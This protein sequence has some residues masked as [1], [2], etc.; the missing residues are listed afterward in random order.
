MVNTR[1]QAWKWS[2]RI[3]M[4]QWFFADVANYHDTHNVSE[5]RGD[6]FHELMK[7][8]ISSSL[9]HYLC[10]DWNKKKKTFFYVEEY[11]NE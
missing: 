9:Y 6:L 2:D 4:V 10:C 11:S 1:M 7:H 8:T 5:N 3:F